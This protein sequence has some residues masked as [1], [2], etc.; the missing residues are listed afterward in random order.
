[1]IQAFQYVARI[2]CPALQFKSE[3]IVHPDEVIRYI[4][5]KECSLSYNPLQ[6][7]LFWSTA[8]TRD[9]RLLTYSLQKRW[10]IPPACAW[11][12]YIRCHDDIGWTFSDE[13]AA[14]LGINGQSHRKFLNRFF[15]GRFKGSYAKGEPFQ[16]NPE[17]GDCR[18][19]GTAASLA[20]LEQAEVLGNEIFKKMAVARMKMMYAV[21]FALPGIPLLYAN[22]EKAVLNDYSYHEDSNKKSDSRWVH[23]IKT[24]WNI[25]EQSEA[26]KDFEQ[27][28]RRKTKA[29]AVSLIF[30]MFKIYTFSP[31]DAVLYI[32]SQIFPKLL[33]T[34]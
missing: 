26:Q 1:M 16:L 6:M 18:I 27:F 24:Y 29:Y 23:R 4:G 30:K 14:E 28:L 9:T 10:K 12:N 17:T 8:A 34:F 21:M 31:L 11:V 13:D 7:A 5:K 32:L 3:A 25:D 2:A 19:C 20:G 33:Q 22:D 15:T